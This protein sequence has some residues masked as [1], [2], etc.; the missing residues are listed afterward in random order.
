MP[1]T[2]L[3]HAP[4]C[5]VDPH[6][7]FV[8]V[9]HGRTRG[10]WLGP[11]PWKL[12]AALSVVAKQLASGDASACRRFL[13]LLPRNCEGHCS[14]PRLGRA[15]ALWSEVEREQYH[16]TTPCSKPP[17][18]RCPWTGWSRRDWGPGPLRRRR[19]RA[20]S[21]GVL[22]SAAPPLAVLGPFFSRWMAAKARG[23]SGAAVKLIR[24]KVHQNSNA[25][26]DICSRRK[27]FK[28]FGRRKAAQ[29]SAYKNVFETMYIIC[30]CVCIYIYMR[31]CVYM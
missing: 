3:L 28:V 10:S 18:E 23:G 9:S 31:V 7:V 19:Q 20:C 2:N 22:R 24:K 21:V 8:A 11:L 29:T 27:T 26:H 16:I 6:V 30:M 4:V 15:S 5:V 13:S 1:S 17:R 12:Y 14:K 25:K